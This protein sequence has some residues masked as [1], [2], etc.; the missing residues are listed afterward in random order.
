MEAMLDENG[1]LEYVKT[2][3]AKPSQSDAQ[4]LAQWKKDVAKTRR[5]ILKGV[6]DH[7]VSN[8]HGKETPF[9][10]WKA[11]TELFENNIDHRKLALKDKLRNIKMQKK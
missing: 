5:I 8:L 4:Q 6:R 9:A 7:V 1:M 11:L 3:I 2:E 10:M